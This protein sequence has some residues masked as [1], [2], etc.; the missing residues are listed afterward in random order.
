MK[1]SFHPVT[2]QRW[3]RFRGMRRGWW[4]FWMLLGAYVLSLFSEWIA[5]DRP[6]W[7]R[8]EGRNYF[9]VVK[10]YPEDVFTGSGRMTRPDYQALAAGEAFDSGS[11]NRMVWPPIP[12]GPLEILKPGEIALPDHV[13]VV[14]RPVVPVASADVDR[15]GRV[16]RVAGEGAVFRLASGDPLASA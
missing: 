14:A 11:G 7:I 8:F 12:Y 1:W 2:R 6:L 13:E 3:A 9:P 5:N 10:F 16:V 15:E 4:A